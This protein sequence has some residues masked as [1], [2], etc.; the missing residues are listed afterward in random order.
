MD[1]QLNFIVS[2]QTI[3]RTDDFKVIAKSVNYLYAHFDFTTDEWDG[4][5][6]TAIF[7]TEDTAYEMI[8]DDNGDCAVPWEVLTENDSYVY[9]S[10]FADNGTIITVNLAKVFVGKTG[11]T[12]DLES[13]QPPTEG[14]Y[15][16]ILSTLQEIRT[17]VDTEVA[18]VREY[19]DTK[20]ENTDGGLFTDWT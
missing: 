8:L 15:A 5:T 11:Y 6:K 1:T 18:E 19:V 4:K 2:N 9:V 12:D 20:T 10:V 17:R 13:S 16:Q 7:A 14:V 3:R